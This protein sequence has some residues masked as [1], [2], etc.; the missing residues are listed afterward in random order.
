MGYYRADRGESCFFFLSLPI[1]EFYSRGQRVIVIF[2]FFLFCLCDRATTRAAGKWQRF[3]AQTTRK[4]IDINAQNRVAYYYIRVC[5]LNKIISI[6]TSVE[7]LLSTRREFRA[8]C[9]ESSKTTV[10]GF[11]FA[12]KKLPVCC[13]LIYF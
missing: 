1:Q 3:S 13:L 11:M 5:L 2:F 8:S 10:S 12:R 7:T 9:C 4:Y 6:V